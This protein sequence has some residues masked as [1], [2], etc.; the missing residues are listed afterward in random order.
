MKL[1][2]INPTMLQERDAI[3]IAAQVLH[4]EDVAYV[5]RGFAVRGMGLNASIQNPGSGS[6]NTVVTE[7][8]A[9]PTGS[10][11]AADFDGDGR[12]DMSV[13]RPA[14]G[15]WYLLLSNSGFTGAAWGL[16]TDRPVPA[17]YDGDR[18]ADLAIFRASAD[19]S[20]A[21]YFILNSSSGT[22]SFV[23]WGS[24]GDIPVTGDYDGDGKADPAIFRPGENRFWV[25]LTSTGAASLSRPMLGSTPVAGDFDGD[26]RT[27]FAVFANGQWSYSRSSDNNQTGVID[28]WGLA[29]DKLVPADYDGDGK[30]DLAVY[31]PS[32]GVWYIKRSSGGIDYVQFGLS[33]DVPVPGDYDGDSR[34]DV[35]VYRDGVWYINRSSSGFAGSQF[36]LSGDLPLPKGY[37][38]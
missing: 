32:D 27:D 20:Q 1:S 6:N 3:L 24:P 38:P 4:P 21:D 16:S 17:D 2:P 8:F 31:R 22:V 25:R 26:A 15:I 37:I 33:A 11:P 5:W 19:A 28:L 9:V 12:T 10:L 7:S 18:K 35:A 34:A 23:S 14:D 13:F 30:T 36:G 29:D